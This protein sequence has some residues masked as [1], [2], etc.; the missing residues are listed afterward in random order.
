METEQKMTDLADVKRDVALLNQFN[1]EVVKP[2]L[3]KLSSSI[4][5]LDVVG[6]NEF[7]QYKKDAKEEFVPQT[8]Y[9]ALK[10]R[11]NILLSAV[12]VMSTGFIIWLVNAII[13][14][15]SKH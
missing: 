10:T 15:V 11:V 13:D 5:N 6:R 8:D 1:R 12:S 7:E 14:L 2:A 3:E 4:E 9:I